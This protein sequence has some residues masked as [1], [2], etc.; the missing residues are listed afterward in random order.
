MYV[1]T[2]KI[3]TMAE[4]K[5]FQCPECGLH[6]EDEAVAKQCEAFCEEHNGCSLEIT[7]FS[8]ERAKSGSA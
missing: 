3:I 1:R 7:R 4:A 5:V 6:Y 2:V 8:V